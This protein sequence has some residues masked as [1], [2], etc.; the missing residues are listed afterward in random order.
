MDKLR[1]MALFVATAER[2]SFSAAGRL[3][4]LSPASV[5]RH[6][7]E[8]ESNLG[9]TLIH[10]STRA[11][12]LTESGLTYLPEARDILSR[13]RAA[14]T[15]L[16]DQTQLPR[17]LL[18]V[19]SRTMFGI[20][21]LAP[22][23]PALATLYPDLVV[24]LHL[25]E[26]PARLREDGF[27]L[28]FRIAPPAENGLVRRRLFLSRRLLVAAPAYLARHPP[29]SGPRD[30]LAHACLT[31]WINHERV[32]WQFRDGQ[33]K[34]DIAI[35]TAFSSNNG[36]VLLTMA[37][38]GQSVALL[39][40]YTVADHLRSGALVQILPRLRVTNTT[41]EEG[42]FVAYSETTFMPTK[43]RCYIDFV[44]GHWEKALQRSETI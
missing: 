14:D 17:G 41:F 16:A 18:R 26:K 19:H 29:I 23:H 4:G 2:G 8:L 1:A 25:S 36:L 38:A 22:L 43:L 10:R 5:S 24:D 33:H 6:V 30:L 32:C 27:D 39:D 21:V 20:S 3:Y 9:V 15:A 34:E 13:V 7:D 28:D 37:L 35:S 31:Y 42:I 40:E 11:L 44:V 12:S